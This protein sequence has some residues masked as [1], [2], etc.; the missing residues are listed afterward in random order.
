MTTDT[1][2]ARPTALLP[3]ESATVVVITP[4]MA[5]DWLRLNVRNRTLSVTKIEQFTNDMQAGAWQVTNQGLGFDRHGNLIDGQHRLHAVIKAGVAVRMMVV[6]NLAPDAQANIDTGRAR[7][8][9]DMLSVL[10]GVKNATNVAA[11]ARQA[12]FWDRGHRWLNTSTATHREVREYVSD[13]AHRLIFRAAEISSNAR[14]LKG[15]IRPAVLGLAYYVC[16]R[17]DEI[18]AETF[19]VDL[20]IDGIG[21]TANHPVLALK[22]RLAHEDKKARTVVDFNKMAYIVMAWNKWRKGE[23]ITR[24]NAPKSGWTA[25][26][27]P[28]P[29]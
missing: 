20:L 29:I 1:T 11:I 19:F 26:N 28:N 21:V 9:G 3:M 6:R 24:L 25:D 2:D 18:D 5:R 15:L 10:D 27:F 4:E 8:P 12:I 17:I 13:P 22:V 14:S 16:A 7:T 23:S